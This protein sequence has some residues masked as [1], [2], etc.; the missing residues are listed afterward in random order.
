MDRVGAMRTAL[1]R[2][3]SDSP[4]LVSQLY[5]LKN[6]LVDLDIRIN[7]SKVKAEIGEVDGSTIDSRLG[8]ARRGLST[9]YGPT[10]MHQENLDIAKSELM[11]IESE[12]DQITRTEIP[13]LER[14]LQASGAPWIAGQAL[15]RS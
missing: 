3:D 5:G 2:T 12:L 13:K 8:T 14:A 6:N 9:T 1:G 7:G 11:E 15:P 4:D 10:A